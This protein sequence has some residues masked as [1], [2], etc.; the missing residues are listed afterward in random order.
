VW[1]P[2]RDGARSSG[3]PS[4]R[5]PSGL[6]QDD[7]G[8]EGRRAAAEVL[9]QLIDARLLT[10]YEVRDAD[11]VPTRRVEIIHESLLA[12]W[13]RLVR[14]Q[15]QDQEGAQLRDELRQSARSWDE[16]G[17]QED[18]LW[19]G[20]A[21]REFQLWRERYPGGL[22]ELEES[23]AAAMVSLATRRRRRRR[24]AVG[25]VIA[26]LLVGLSVVGVFWQRSVREARRAE[27]QKLNALANLQLEDNPSATIAYT[28]ASLGL[29]DSE[30]AR[31]LALE[32]LWKGPTAFVVH[33][34]NTYSPEF[35]TD[36]GWLVHAV[37]GS[38]SGLRLVRSDGRII[39]LDNPHKTR[40]VRVY[41]G[42]RDDV[43]LTAD[44]HAE[45]SPWL[46]VFWSARD[47]SRLAE[48]RYEHDVTPVGR[49]AW[50]EDC[51][52]QPVLE[53]SRAY[54]DALCFD[55]TRTRLGDLGPGLGPDGERPIYHAIDENSGRWCG[56][57]AGGDV[58]VREIS[59]TDIG[60]PRVLGRSDGD[61][62]RITFDPDGRYFATAGEP[63]VIRLWDPTGGSPPIIVNGPATEYPWLVF[64]TAG[65]G[66]ILA[67][68]YVDSADDHHKV[69]MWSVTDAE[70]TMLRRFDLGLQVPANWSTISWGGG[71]LARSDWDQKTRLWRFSAPADAEPTLVGRNETGGQLWSPRYDPQGKWLATSSKSGLTFYPL[72]GPI[73]TVMRHGVRSING[74]QF[75]P[76]GDWVVSTGGL[77][78]VKIWPLAGDVPPAGRV[79]FD[80][81]PCAIAV[82]PDGEHIVVGTQKRTGGDPLL[83][84]DGSV[85]R[86]FTGFEFQ[87][88]GLAFSPSGRMVAGAGG[89]F[90]DSG[91][92]I[93]IWDVSTGEVL[94]VL[95][96]A[97][98]LFEWKLHFESE[99]SLLSSGQGGLERWNLETG[100][101]E[102]LHHEMVRAFSVSGDGRRVL[103]VEHGIADWNSASTVG[104]P[105]VLDLD[106]G[107]QWQL[108]N[109]S[110]GTS[111]VALDS[112]GTIVATGDVNGVIRVGPVTGEEPHVLLG[113][114]SEVLDIAFDPLGRWIASSGNTPP[115]ASGPCPTSPGR[116]CTPCR[117][118]S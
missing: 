72:E 80:N 118:R 39:A 102:V 68:K 51:V 115:S 66:S 61:T 26:A 33:E 1:R 55:G 54:L 16:H 96:P 89:T 40:R 114:Q 79:I 13:P 46:F 7:T 30:Q 44:L 59:A 36:G 27:A 43:F 113:H 31:L 38:P 29:A 94:M 73:A 71:W 92:V 101:S 12:A 50:R 112:S 75:S 100:E 111:G 62:V 58:I 86:R 22:T 93:R 53:E 95:E 8:I 98:D 107:A 15:T 60:P 67:L 19:T 5:P 34:E 3:D 6:A 2:D 25:T 10:S 97:A 11:E 81:D 4:T 85:V 52:L 48:I 83:T 45:P 17:R 64:E 37:E 87:T 65:G 88:S 57:V 69:W 109:H 18:R 106:T 74:V 21:F 24:I 63:E 20:T 103:V 90:R 35:G 28:L 117:V 49:P 47:G 70:P 76:T 105:V 116:R 32:A 42:P 104:R 82:S 99:D 110:I 78:E 84:V 56:T 108:E 23:F 41:T 14:W 9:R 91:N 77:D